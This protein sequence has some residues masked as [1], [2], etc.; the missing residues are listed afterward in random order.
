MSNQNDERAPL[1]Q[2]TR[3][4]LEND[5]R[6]VQV[7][8]SS[9]DQDNPRAWTRRQKLANVAV[10]ASMAILSPLASSMFTP[11]ISEIAEGLGTTPDTVIGATTSYV[12]MLGMGPLVLAPLS[13]TF[14]RKSLYLSCFTFFSLVQIPTAFSPNIETMITLRAFSGFFGSVSIANG[15]GT[16]SDMFWPEE[17]ATVFG[18]YLIG[19]LLGP[20]IGPLLG[21]VIVQRLGWR[22]VF[23]TLAL[24]C[25][26]SVTSGFFFLRETYVLVLLQRRKEQQEKEDGSACATH[27]WFEGED[28]RP[29]SVKLWHSFSRPLR[30]LTQPVVLT[31]SV[32]QALIFST[33]HS[34][35]TNFEDIYGG[36]YGFNTEQV[37]LA[38]LGPG[39]GLLFAVRMIVPHIDDVYKKPRDKNHGVAK[40]EFRL[41]LANIGAVLVPVSLIC[42]AWMVHFHVHWFATIVAAFFYGIGQVVIVNCTQNYYIDAFEKF[43][44]SAIAAGVAFR[45]IFGGVVPLFAPLLFKSVGYGWGIS[46]FGLVGLMLAPAPLLFYHFGERIR[47]CIKH[48]IEEDKVIR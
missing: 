14:G 13:E 27:Y 2:H 16:L 28:L 20:T 37:G 18:W 22:W 34:L 7:K 46:V 17:R 15:G 38:Y 21:G 3:G 39:L 33:T 44:A 40:P 12:V 9:D 45:S 32:Y 29:M 19:P 1:L 36:I 26:V 10:I 30:I 43:A 31:M 4:N 24:L 25:G 6:H 5:E 41:P 48:D 35:Y 23:L 47:A 11:G 42:F 8:F